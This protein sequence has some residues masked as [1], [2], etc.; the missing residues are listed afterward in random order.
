MKQKII[1][2]SGWYGAAAILAAYALLSFGVLSAHGYAYQLLNLTGAAGIVAVSLAKRAY[3]PAALN[4]VWV[5]I[6]VVALVSLM[7]R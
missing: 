1:E 5:I 4:I 3:Q 6:A 7:V 2:L